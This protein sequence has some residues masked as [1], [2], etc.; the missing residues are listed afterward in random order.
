MVRWFARNPL[1][2]HKFSKQ[3]N[4]LMSTKKRLVVVAL[5]CT[6]LGAFGQKADRS[7]HVSYLGEYLTHP[8]LSIGYSHALYS[9]TRVKTK[10]N[11]KEKQKDQKVFLL[12]SLGAYTQPKLSSGMMLTTS[13]GYRKT[14]ARGFFLQYMVGAGVFRS[15][16]SGE[17]YEVSDNGEVSTAAFAGRT[18]FINTWSM[19]MGKDFSKTKDLP[20]AV[21]WSSG[22]WL[23]YPYNGF[24]LP[25]F[26]GELGISYSF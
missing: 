8:G 23:R 7:V 11:G 14:R 12:H 26:S 20:I 2:L 21:Y 10:H 1:S 17:T 6:S 5:L 4:H 16:L 13:L 19:G 18:S 3:T 22:L 15:L 25:Q 24:I 9:R